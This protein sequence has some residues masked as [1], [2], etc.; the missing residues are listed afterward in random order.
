MK[1]FYLLNDM[2]A[3]SVRLCFLGGSINIVANYSLAN[4]KHSY[5]VQTKSLPITYTT[6]ATGQ[7]SSLKVLS[8]DPNKVGLL[9]VLMHQALLSRE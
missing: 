8:L 9:R 7:A 2:T 5:E 3:W 1:D 4:T 6:P